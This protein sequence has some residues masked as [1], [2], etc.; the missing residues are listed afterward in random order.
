MK[1]L[2]LVIIALMIPSIALAGPY[3][4]AAGLS[5]STAVSMDDASLLSWASAWSGYEPGADV[6]AQWQDPDQALGAAQGTA[7]DIVCLGRGGRI[8]LEFPETV[9][10]GP[11][12]DLA[13]FENS[14]S[15]VFL[16][17]AY[18]EVSSDG[19]NFV[20]FPSRSLTENPV[21]TYGTI[22]PTDLDGLA[23]KYRQGFGTPFDLQVL[24]GEDLV[25]SG[26][27]N[28]SRIRYLRLID[29]NGDG[30][31]FDSLGSVIYDPYPTKGSAGFDLDAVAARYPNAAGP[32]PDNNP[33]DAPVPA[34]PAMDEV[35]AGTTPELSIAGFSDP[36]PEDS[37]LATQWQL[38]DPAQAAQPLFEKLGITDLLSCAVPGAILDPDSQYAWRARVLDGSALASAWSDYYTFT[39]AGPDP[40]ADGNGVPDAEQADWDADGDGLA[41]PALRL[42]LASGGEILVAV[43]PVANVAQVTAL[44]PEDPARTGAPLAPLYFAASPLSFRATVTDP[45]LPARV[46]LIFSAPLP[47]GSAWYKLDPDAGWQ[48][49]AQALIACG[50]YC[51]ELTL[52]DGNTALGDADG[53]KNGI[54]VDPGAV[55]ARTTAEAQASQP[56]GLGGG[57]GCFVGSLYAGA[58]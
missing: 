23:G 41:D 44:R 54:I 52:A 15:D 25:L 11:G 13:V 22:D 58:Q 1:K 53:S 21:S 10:N 32:A 28:L 27:V 35:V 34:A 14:F 29:V 26:A 20:R 50:G 37:H 47:S 2:V 51:I 33:P 12:Y 56:A 48:P 45:D 36:D 17:L 42:A 18:V 30:S 6:D 9:K 4:P 7:F 31:A 8:T 16:E 19:R 57:S 49:Y 40:D 3:P 24:A 55:V 38:Y 5:G 46:R 39:T 43:I